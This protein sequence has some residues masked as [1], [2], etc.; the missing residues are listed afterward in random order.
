MQRI[1]WIIKSVS[2]ILIFFILFHAATGIFQDKTCADEYKVFWEEKIDNYDMLL[3]GTSV[4]RGGVSPLD[5]WHDYGIVSYNLAMSGQTLELNYYNIKS[6]IKFRKPKIIVADVTYI[7]N[8]NQYGAEERR[9]Q[10]IDNMPWH[11]GKMG[12]IVSMIKPE[13][14]KD[15]F[16]N[17]FF[18]HSRWKDLT[19][20]DFTQIKSLNK[21]C[22]LASFSRDAN[23]NFFDARV[24]F[25]EPLPII[26]ETE[27]QEIPEAALE[28]VRKIVEL[29]KKEEIELV[30]VAYPCYAW[31]EVNHGDGAELQ[32]MWNQFYDVA[33]E[34]DI[35]YINYM[36]ELDRIDFDPCEDLADWRHLSYTGAEKVT[37]DLG[38]FLVSEYGLS[39]RHGDPQLSEWDA[40]WEELEEYK[41]GLGR[42][43][44]REREKIQEGGEG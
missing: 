41:A 23:G 37:N 29:C 26:P 22:N 4:A 12:T 44:E 2:F 39:D 21:G 17:L 25:S 20:K 3:F 40:Q 1:K 32:K 19:A 36:H 27:K 15:Y 6:A 35:K 14:W 24:F 18:Y 31:G 33:A 10:L 7:F 34:Y 11:H 28:Y 30:F 5:L 9:H 38:S 42:Q 16:L 13:E 43:K 8:S